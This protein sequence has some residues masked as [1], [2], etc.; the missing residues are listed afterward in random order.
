MVYS[1]KFVAVI[2]CNG[3]ILREVNENEVILPFGAEYSILLKNLDNRR[4]VVNV[5]IDGSDVLNGRRLVIDANKESELKG[6]MINNSVRNAFKFI[7]KTKKIQDH[8]G[9]K[10]D[11]GLIRIKFGFERPVLSTTYTDYT[12][13]TV[14]RSFSNHSSDVYGNVFNSSV[15]EGRGISGPVSQAN[16]VVMDS[17]SSVPQVD[18]GI[19][20]PGS[21]LRQDF[22]TTYVGSIEDYGTIILQLK[23]T[24]V[25]EEPVK[26]PIFVST[27]LEC[28]TCGTKSR[29]GT[30]F[31]SECG[32]NLQA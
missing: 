14:Y 30:K 22:N 6:V 31:C 25:K 8:R 28:P 16:S 32:T 29:Y 17:L 18:E 1:K 19:T 13:P 5:T 3:K 12:Y 21:E 10:I 20:V 26:T 9:D 2:K 11:D 24:D 23:G 4:S 15:S 7:Q 27:K